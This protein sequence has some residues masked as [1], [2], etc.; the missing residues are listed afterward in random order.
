MKGRALAWLISLLLMGNIILFTGSQQDGFKEGKPGSDGPLIANKT[1]AVQLPASMEFA[2]EPVPLDDFNAKERLDRELLINTYWQSSTVYL[3]KQ[4]NRYF[5]II[6]PILKEHNIPEDFKFLA[7]AESGL[8][9]LVSPSNAVGIW[10]FLKATGKSYDLEINGEVDERYHLEKATVAACAY[11]KDAYG[12][13]GNWTMAAAAYNMGMENL[14]KKQDKQQVKE[15]EKDYLL[16][17]KNFSLT[18]KDSLVVACAP[19]K[20]KAFEAAWAVVTALVRK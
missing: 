7:L 3:F 5:P 16:L 4:S 15:Y 1:Y 14:Q 12:M 11:L 8:Q 18:S 9:N 13:F 6:I 20:E 17:E 19:T 2:G 10:Q